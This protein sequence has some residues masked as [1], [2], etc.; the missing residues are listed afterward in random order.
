MTDSFSRIA[1]FVVLTASLIL[2]LASA[3]RAAA[4]DVSGAEAAAQSQRLET[5]RRMY[6]EGILPSGE[7]MRATVGGDISVTGEQ[8]VCGACHRRS[9]MG[10]SEAQEVAPAVTGDLLYAPLRLPTSKPP[11]APLI[12]PAYT[13]ETLKRAIRDGIDAN[14][15]AFGPF[16]P[17]Y[18]LSD[19]ELDILIAYLKSLSASPA[20][21]VTAQD[22]HFATIV[23]DSAPPASRKALLD[24]MQAFFEQK[25][26]ETRHESKR[27]AHAPWHKAWVFSP[28]RKW[29][30]HVWELHGPRET[31]PEQLEA[32]YREQPV[33]AVLSGVAPGSWEPMHAFCEGE[34]I[35]CLFPTTD[36]PVIDEEAFYTLYLSQGVTL[37][38]EALVQHLADEDRLGKPLVQVFDA[39]DPRGGVAADALR[40]AVTERGGQVTDFAVEAKVAP[41]DSF[42]QAALEAARETVLV[43]WLPGSECAPVWDRSAAGG[44]PAQ[45]YLSQTLYASEPAEVPATLRERVYL[46]YP[47]ELPSRLPRLLARSTGWM[48]VKKIYAP[49]QQQVQANAYFAMKM[50]GGA[51][52]NIRGFFNRDYFLESIEHMV[53]TAS[54]TSVYPHVSLA[55]NQRFVSKG[56]YIAQLSEDG[57]GEPV[58]VSGWLIPG[59]K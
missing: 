44:Q 26:A 9:G 41:G 56:C 29:V 34:Q 11:E 19:E 46:T 16:M 52:A 20:P 21:G 27:A 13:D 51:L 55:P 1:P 57:S 47:Y 7:M 23:A 42:W 59:L 33:F 38:A 5:G 40:R 37:E 15:K 32:Y 25:N 50:A 14:G 4:A 12:R 49:D 35:P 6:R 30:L 45:I 3:T 48:R 43:L 10:A 36:L 8:V 39:A 2:M 54:Y 58:A 22:I 17:R 18:P 24:V 28:Y 31:W 53:D